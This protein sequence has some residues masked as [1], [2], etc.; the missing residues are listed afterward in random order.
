MNLKEI[1]ETLYKSSRS[2][3]TRALSAIAQAEIFLQQAYE[4]RYF[5]ELIQNVRDAN[6]E[7][8]QDGEIFIELTDN[9]LSIS[10]TGAEFSQR[11]IESITTIGKSTKHSQDF[12]G[13]KGI[14]FK[15]IQEITNTPQI[16]TRYGT[17]LFDRRLTIKKYNDPE[18]LEEDVPL[19]YFPHFSEK[20]LSEAEISSGIVTKIELPLKENSSMEAIVEGFNQ[21]QAQQLVLLGNIRYLGFNSETF[22]VKFVINKN[23]KKNYL[24]VRKDESEIHR[25]R[26]FSPSKKIIIPDEIVKSLEGKEKNIF[27]NTP[28]VDINIVLKLNDKGQINPIDNSELYLFY[29]LK[30]TSGFRFIIHSYFIVNPERKALRDSPLNSFLL[31]AIGEFIGNEM[32]KTL[33]EKR[34]NT[35]KILS[36]KRNSDAKLDRLY[37]TVIENLKNQKFIYDNQTKKYYSANEVIV[38]DDF[39]KGLFRDGKLGNKQLVY[40]DDDITRDWLR[41]EF[42]IPYLTFEKI[43]EEIEEECKGQVKTRNLKFFQNLYNYVSKF[44]NLN[45]T[46][47]RVL[48]TD[49]WKLVSSED[50]VFYIGKKENR[51][52]LPGS[53]AQHI[54]FINAGIKIPDLRE[55]RSRTG[56]IEYSKHELVKRLLKLLNKET[57]PKADILNVLFNLELDSKSELEIKEKIL[58]PIKGK[59]KWLSPLTN[60]IYF[61]TENLRDLYPHGNFVDENVL[62]V[63]SSNQTIDKKPFL[64]MFGVWDIPAIYV[65]TKRLS[66]NSWDKRERILYSISNLSSRPFFL[67][68]DRV[69]DR[70]RKFN[71]WFTQS[72]IENWN[73]YRAFILSDLL[74]RLLYD[75]EMSHLLRS[76]PKEA[77]LKL[78]DFIETLRTQ[79][80]IVFSGEE[81]AYS[82]KDVIGI[83]TI[84]FRQPHNQ[85]IKKYGKLFPVNYSIKR[86]LLTLIEMIHLDGSS[87]EN[88]ISLLG[89]IYEKYKSKNHLEKD[90][91]DFYNRILSKLF[92]FYYFKKHQAENIGRLREQYF[93]AIDEIDKNNCWAKSKDIFYIDDKLNYDLLP[94]EIK[95]ELQP[96]FTNRDKNTFGKIAAKIGKK[97]SDSIQKELIESEPLKQLPL[98]TYF[99]NLP[100]SIAILE[101][102]LEIV[103]SKEIDLLR[104]IRVFEKDKIKIRISIAGSEAIEIEV[105]HF[106]DDAPKFDLHLS[107]ASFQNR[108]KLI[109]QTLSEL[110][111]KILDRDLR[112]FNSDLLR[113]LNTQDKK[114]YLADYEISEERIH[115]I[116][117]KLNA[118]DL[119]LVQKFWDAILLAKGLSDRE[120]IFIEKDINISNLAES[121]QVT[122]ANIQDFQDSFNFSDINNVSN[123]DAINNLLNLLSLSLIKLN[124][125]LFPKIDFKDYYNRQLLQLK[126][127]FQ[128]GFEASLHNHLKSRSIREQQTY[129]NTIDTYKQHFQLS[130]PLNSIAINIED[131]FVNLLNKEFK[132]IKFTTANLSKSFDDFNP[133][134]IYKRQYNLLTSELKSISYTPEQLERFLADNKRRSLLYFNEIQFLVD[135]F[136]DWLKEN[137]ARNKS[138]IENELA[139][140]LSEFSNSNSAEIESVNVKSVNLPAT[141]QGSATGSSGTRFDGSSG[142]RNKKNIGIV[143]EMLVFKKLREKYKHVSWVSKNASKIPK[144][145]LGYNPEGDDS[146][147]YDIE[148]LDDEG[149]KFFVEVKGR[150]DSTDSFEITKNEI[151]KAH[152]AKEFYKVIFVTN[153]MDK[154][155]RRIRDLGNLFLLE[156]GEDFFTNNKFTAIYKSFE[157]R[158]Q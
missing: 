35:T 63:D 56:I 9:T 136:V 28:E 139:D 106:V 92:D 58:L 126:N 57:V 53:I 19:F 55:G 130:V 128:K 64:K 22:S 68:N 123:I 72:I 135:R 137:E 93:L 80:W 12:I 153:T 76:A 114:E 152:Q 100:E 113:Y 29:P 141:G 101:S 69:L 32:L 46:G 33:K 73:I 18:L 7:I 61:D 134:E 34:N 24:E 74:P 17:V 43:A 148:Y 65:Y 142:E 23:P 66:I 138:G 107:N 44:D 118:S 120:A 121:L 31:K 5:F 50:D 111:V 116:K 129:Q 81:V 112:K 90:F 88:Y 79:K 16:V 20:K 131:F 78:S 26:N 158:F 108:N 99:E 95:Q 97:F 96:H 62:I 40:I 1:V 155:S 59:G 38:A 85:V 75:S 84:E 150:A 104:T 145:R 144:N 94:L 89:S 6:K 119:S 77:L 3:D 105:N 71:S 21:I 122:P 156:N 51:I 132:F 87:I 149:N 52:N 54:K 70:P 151:E 83:D 30:I 25:F 45:L 124:E 86:E 91:V 15:S 41:N 125:F 48:L 37:D 8:E 154:S 10:N 147:G 49:D 98:I 39:D 82:V 127:K 140:L 67:T 60:P 110:F 36:F 42:S 102:S 2:A 157:I 13:F 11:G 146:L 27:S 109:A 115:E 133:N 4:G 14:G 103:L 143:A 117:D 47:R